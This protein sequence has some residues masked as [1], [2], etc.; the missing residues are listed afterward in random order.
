MVHVM[1]P[2]LELRVHLA[3]P[4]HAEFD[5]VCGGDGGP[6]IIDEIEDIRIDVVGVTGVE[7]D[8][9][10]ARDFAE[11]LFEGGFAE[12]TDLVGEFDAEHFT[13]SVTFDDPADGATHVAVEDESDAGGGSD[14]NPDQQIGEEDSDDGGDEGNELAFPFV[15][16][17]A[18]Q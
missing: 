7:Q 6:E 13:G 9:P 5:S 3:E 17:L 4:D 10:A 18:E 16:H 12:I 14:E 2:V 1:D 8:V 11:D 15:P